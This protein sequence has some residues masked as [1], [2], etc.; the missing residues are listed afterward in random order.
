M[1]E[2]NIQQFEDLL[3]HC[4][5]E[6]IREFEEEEEVMM[7]VIVRMGGRLV[8]FIEDDIE[9]GKLVEEVKSFMNL[10]SQHVL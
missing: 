3:E 6:E 10:F 2:D 5:E 1:D 4:L 7:D 8:A 9:L